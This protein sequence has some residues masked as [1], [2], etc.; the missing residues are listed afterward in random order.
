MVAASHETATTNASRTPA[1][2]SQSS[3][4][5]LGRKPSSSATAR[6]SSVDAALR[7]TLA[8]TWPPST[9]APLTS[10]DRRRS[11]IPPVMSWLTLTAVVAEP[12]PAHSRMTPGTTYVT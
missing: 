6:T 2:A 9:A 7:T 12:N 4:P 5:A 1:T 8:A 3:G 10:I 11:T